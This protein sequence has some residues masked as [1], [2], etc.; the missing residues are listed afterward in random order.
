MFE[1]LALLVVLAVSVVVVGGV[2]MLAFWA[3]KFTLSIA[4]LPLKLLF[5]PVLAV[6]FIVKVAVLFAVGAVI[7]SVLLAVVIPI[8]VALAVVAVPVA[9]V[10][11][12]T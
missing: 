9:L 5:I 7:V 10:A 1:L 6:V 2:L 4:I 12:L 3:V 8:L 11:A